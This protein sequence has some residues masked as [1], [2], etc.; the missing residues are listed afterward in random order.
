MDPEP[1]NLPQPTNVPFYRNAVSGK[2]LKDQENGIAD[3]VTLVV[4]QISKGHFS[5][6]P[7][8]RVTS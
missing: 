8:A 7:I 3:Q 6:S 1:A 5:A 4:F 2:G